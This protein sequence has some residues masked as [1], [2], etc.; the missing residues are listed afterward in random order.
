M[1]ILEKLPRL[2]FC[3]CCIDL[4]TGAIILGILE[5]LGALTSWFYFIE[6]TSIVI[7]GDKIPFGFSDGNL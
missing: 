2:K 4:P 3:C 5:F 6:Y 7:K 1:T